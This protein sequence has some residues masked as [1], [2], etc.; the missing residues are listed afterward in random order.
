MF[1]LRCFSLWNSRCYVI[2]IFPVWI[3]TAIKICLWNAVI[4]IPKCQKSS[5]SWVGTSVTNLYW[6]LFQKPNYISES[7]GW[8]G[9]SYTLFNISFILF[10]LLLNKQHLVSLCIFLYILNRISFSF[11][12]VLCNLNSLFSK[13]R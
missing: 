4:V 8:H 1:L 12:K 13:I 9:D 5:W 7:S 6:I 2:P 3:V 10:H 11:I